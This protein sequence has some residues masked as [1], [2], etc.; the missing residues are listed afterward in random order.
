MK[1]ILLLL[2]VSIG[3]Y[4]CLNGL[5]TLKE[6]IQYTITNASGK[7]SGADVVGIDVSHHQGNIDWQAVARGGVDFVY[8]KATEGATYIDAKFRHNAHEAH[9]AGLMVGA[10]HYFRMTSSVDEQFDNFKKATLGLSLDLIPMID[11]ET[12][13]GKSKK[14]VQRNLDKFIELIKDEYGVSPMIYGTQRSYNE[15]C[16]PKYNH[17][18]LYIGRYGNQPPK[19]LGNGGYT[20]WQYTENGTVEGIN[21]NVDKCRF[22]PK[23]SLDDIRLKK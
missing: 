18:H 7:A 23:Y 17:L 8:I 19:L 12:S 5:P 13:D 15:L 20:I 22:N 21:K 6:E 4:L 10:Y 9:K 16:A 11:V 14:G 2:S 3:S 1:K